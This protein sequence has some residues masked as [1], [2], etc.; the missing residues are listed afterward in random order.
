MRAVRGWMR[1]AVVGVVVGALATAGVVAAASLTRIDH[2]AG[3]TAHAERG[4]QL[5]LGPPQGRCHRVAVVGDSL[6]DNSRPWLAA[7]LASAGYQYVIEAQPS[8][9]IPSTVRRPYSGVLAALDLRRSWGEADCWLIALGSNDLYWGAGTP[10]IA[11][12]LIDEML[13]AVTPGARVWWMNVDYHRDPRTSFDFP[14][15]STAFN[16]ELRTAEAQERLRVIDW[17]ALAEANLQW[18]FDPVHVDRPGSIVRAQ[19]M[20]A[21]LAS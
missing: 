2:A 1:A 10:A 17:Y 11:R 15:A 19:Q 3:A 8:R 12:A 14:R 6:T 7:G 18:F 16:A 5:R 21:A 20:V 9:R 4:E 13:A